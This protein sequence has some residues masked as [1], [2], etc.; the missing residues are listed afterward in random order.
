[1]QGPCGY[2]VMACST[3]HAFTTFCLDG[4]NSHACYSLHTV[5]FYLASSTIAV[6]RNRT[7][8]KPSVAGINPV[9]SSFHDC[10]GFW[11]EQGVRS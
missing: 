6:A 11:T 5:R 2:L 1:M 7:R 9:A 8:N 10:Y 4:W 3:S